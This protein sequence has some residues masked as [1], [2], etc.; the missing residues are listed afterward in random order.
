MP[1]PFIISSAKRRGEGDLK[2]HMVTDVGGETRL[3]VRQ[4]YLSDED[5]RFLD[6]PLQG[7]L[8]DLIK[9][10]SNDVRTDRANESGN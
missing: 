5:D 4:H 3:V 10:I 6:T 7:K 2:S 8:S 9:E 1:L